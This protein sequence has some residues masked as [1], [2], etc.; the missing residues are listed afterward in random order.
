[1]FQTLTG[2]LIIL[3]SMLGIIFVFALL[4]TA[5]LRWIFLTEVEAAHT[6]TVYQPSTEYPFRNAA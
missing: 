4:M 6:T 5:W 3:V 2:S 1:M